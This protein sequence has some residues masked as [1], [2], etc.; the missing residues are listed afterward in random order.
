MSNSPPFTVTKSN[1][2]GHIGLRVAMRAGGWTGASIA[3]QASANLSTTDARELAAALIRQADA[4]DAKVEKKQAH[5]VRRRKWKDREIAA[6]R[7]RILTPREFL[8]GR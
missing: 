8:G 4:E 3:V 7:I 1:K 2:A 6:G 5:E